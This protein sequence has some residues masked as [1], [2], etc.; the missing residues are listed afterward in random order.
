MLPAQSPRI[1]FLLLL[2]LPASILALDRPPIHSNS[3]ILDALPASHPHALPNSAEEAR[4]VPCPFQ[5]PRTHK[6]W[7]ERL[8]NAIDSLGGAVLG[9]L[10]LHDDASLSGIG[11]G[12]GG[13]SA[14]TENSVYVEVC[15]LRSSTFPQTTTTD[16]PIYCSLP[17]HCTPPDH[18]LSV[19]T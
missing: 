18:P 7:A 17:T 19:L 16:H 13:L 2:L 6:T 4:I 12:D 14:L 1:L 15:P 11:L 10:G 8:D 3:V 5:Q 9:L